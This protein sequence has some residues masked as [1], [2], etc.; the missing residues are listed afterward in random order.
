LSGCQ[1]VG[2]VLVAQSRDEG[3]DAMS[4]IETQEPT[5]VLG[6]IPMLPL[7]SREVESLDPEIAKAEKRLWEKID[8]A[9]KEYSEQVIGITKAGNGRA[10]GQKQHAHFTL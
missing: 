9:L 10:R 7:P 1:A 5:R 3:T 6:D 4:N 2:P 8:S